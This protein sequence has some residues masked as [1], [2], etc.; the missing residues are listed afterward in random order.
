VSQGA[1]RD[2]GG[3]GLDQDPVQE[4]V[5]EVGVQADGDLVAGVVLA[6]RELV[7]A[8]PDEPGRVHQPVTLDSSRDAKVTGW[9][10][11]GWRTGRAGAELDQ[12]GQLGGGEPGGHGLEQLP[13]QA[14]MDDLVVDPQPNLLAAIAAAQPQ[15]TAGQPEV[16]TGRHDQL[17]LQ[18]AQRCG[19]LGGPELGRQPQ[20]HPL[21]DRFLG[22]EASRRVA[23]PIA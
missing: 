7:A 17:E 11:G 21:V 4:D 19:G 16:A 12:A 22:M 18:R 5:G 8:Q 6:D 15:L 13:I 10:A 14:E 20:R 3:H 9:D 1:G 2:R 23:I